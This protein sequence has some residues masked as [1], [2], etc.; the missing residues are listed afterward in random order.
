MDCPQCGAENPADAKYCGTCGHA[1][2]ITQQSGTSTKA[3]W[4]NVFKWIGIIV[5][6][7]IVLAIMGF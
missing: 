1:I 4:E 3:K 7:L 5:V 2:K 6:G